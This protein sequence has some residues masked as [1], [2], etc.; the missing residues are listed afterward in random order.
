MTK[1]VA[2]VAWSNGNV[3]M[4]EKGVYDIKD[5]LATDLIAQGLCAD[6]A[7]YFGGGG[8]ALPEITAA[9]NG[10]VLT[11]DSGVW[12]AANP[13]GGGGYTT[14]TLD[15]NEFVLDKTW[16]EIK[17]G[18]ISVI[19]AQMGEEGIAFFHIYEIKVQGGQYYILSMLP[20][21]ITGSTISDFT[22][23]MFETNSE[24]GYPSMTIG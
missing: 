5:A 23:Y 3:T 14:A 24:N 12:V 13:S 11:A 7:T 20:N 1:V 4:E 21:S 15:G 19:V 18:R 9:D 6:A 17:D 2:L 8:S 10:K 16:K 22:Q